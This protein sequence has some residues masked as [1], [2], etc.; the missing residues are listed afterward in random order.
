MDQAR[1][2]LQK[3][4]NSLPNKIKLLRF[5][6]FFFTNVA[7]DIGKGVSFGKENHHSIRKIKENMNPELSFNFS[8]EQ[9]YL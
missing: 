4:V 6:I 7:N 2:F 9:F 1:L 3:I 8:E 5:L